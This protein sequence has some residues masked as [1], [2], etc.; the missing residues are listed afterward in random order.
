MSGPCPCPPPCST[1]PVDGGE[2]L[3]VLREA[4]QFLLAEYQVVAG[5]NL[6]DAATGG[7]E[8]G[9]VSVPG[10]YGIRQT[11]GVGQVVSDL[12]VFDGDAHGISFLK[13]TF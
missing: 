3:V 8:F 7:D 6:E 5:D 9:L 10:S 4:V 13:R 1:L 2:N 11:G 12:A